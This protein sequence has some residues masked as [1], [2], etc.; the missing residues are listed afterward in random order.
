MID[1]LLENPALCSNKSAVQGLEE[2]KLLLN[3][4]KLFGVL[5]NVSHFIRHP[6][7]VLIEVQNSFRVE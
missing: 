2:M 7:V 5:D 1:S 3:Y 4:C 6:R